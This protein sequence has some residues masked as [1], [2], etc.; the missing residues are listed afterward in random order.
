MVLFPP[1]LLRLVVTSLS[2]AVASLLYAFT[3]S[4]VDEVPG[5]CTMYPTGTCTL[6]A[7]STHTA[8]A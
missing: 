8:Q 7:E 1:F 2:A 3:Q 5:F 4:Y 6:S